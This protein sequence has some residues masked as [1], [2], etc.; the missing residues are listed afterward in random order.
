MN[1][2]IPT[3]QKPLTEEQSNRL[4]EFSRDLATL[5]NKHRITI[6]IKTIFSMQTETRNGILLDVSHFIYDEK[7]D[8]IVPVF[9]NRLG[10]P[11]DEE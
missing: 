10:K 7:S 8:E 1:V 6:S 2:P 4:F 5:C 9:V 3:Q 11:N